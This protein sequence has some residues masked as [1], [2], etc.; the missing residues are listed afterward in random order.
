M[1]ITITDD[2][3]YI[4]GRTTGSLITAGESYTAGDSIARTKAT[5]SV[6]GYIVL[7]AHPRRTTKVF[8]V[9]LIDLSNLAE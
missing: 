7:A 1:K 3:S 4:H 9:E 8:E 2:G 5:E 6:I